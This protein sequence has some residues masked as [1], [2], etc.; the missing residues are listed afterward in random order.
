M[1]WV[2]ATVI[3]A[4]A[5]TARNA[6]QSSLTA[7]IG[8]LGATQVRFIYGLPFAALF[9]ATMAVIERTSV[10]APSTAFLGF[11]AAGAI[12]QI[13]GTA[14]Q[15]AAMKARSFSVVERGCAANIEE[16]RQFFDIGVELYKSGRFDAASL[17]FAMAYAFLPFPELV[18][19]LG[20]CYKAMGENDK[21][22]RFFREYLENELP[23]K[24]RNAVR[25]MIRELSSGKK[26]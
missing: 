3:A 20:L 6:M 16:A 17:Q 9:L 1:L 22:I 14:L 11:T 26:P 10:P 15:L 8:T 23:E 5:Q 25:A 12:A 21:A 24:D 2:I 19:N 4:A 18:Y 13:L 7:T